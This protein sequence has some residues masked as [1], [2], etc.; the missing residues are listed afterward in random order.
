MLPAAA[1]ASVTPLTA[2]QQAGIAVG[3]LEFSDGMQDPSLFSSSGVFDFSAAQAEFD[4]LPTTLDAAAQAYASGV[5]SFYVHVG[6]YDPGANDIGEE[7][8]AIMTR[9]G[10][11]SDASAQAV[12]A[13]AGS[14]WWEGALPDTLESGG[15]DLASTAIGTVTLGAGAVFS[16]L[17]DPSA[18]GVLQTEQMVG[19]TGGI[20]PSFTLTSN[21]DGSSFDGCVNLSSD[22]TSGSWSSSCT[23]GADQVPAPE[24][25]P[26][27]LVTWTLPDS[28]TVAGWP[29]A[30]AP[31]VCFQPTYQLGLPFE[32]G[33][34][35]G[36][37][38]ADANSGDTDP[39]QNQAD[40][41]PGQY[42]GIGPVQIATGTGANTPS[43]ATVGS[44]TYDELLADVVANLTGS[45]PLDAFERAW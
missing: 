28:D 26:W 38:C 3:E 25:G 9:N 1:S 11:V 22:L 12:E 36:A 6:W 17:L 10:M 7:E 19:F 29:V 4:N 2:D 24:S 42:L 33:E 43:V 21:V 16:M 39:A 41:L 14:D 8:W 44:P 37:T 40:F 27:N 13:D 45:V 20:I 34:S 32:Q 30:G 35:T 18:A 31:D 23:G 5:A 15:V